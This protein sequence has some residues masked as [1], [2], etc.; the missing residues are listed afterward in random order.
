MLDNVGLIHMNGRVQDPVLGRFVSADPFITEPGNTQNFNRYSYVYNNPLAFTDPSGFD[1]CGSNGGADGSACAEEEKKKAEEAALRAR[2]S[3]AIARAIAADGL[4]IAERRAL[5]AQAN[6][7][8]PIIRMLE[9]RLLQNGSSNPSPNYSGGEVDAEI[10]VA[11]TRHTLE[12]RQL[13]NSEAAGMLAASVMPGL[14]MMWESQLV[15]Q[16]QAAA[17]PV[18]LRAMPAPAAGA[19]RTAPL[20]NMGKQGKH[21]VGHNN[22]IPGRSVLTGNPQVLAQR[23][24]TGSPVGSVA[25]GQAG[26][27]ERVDFGEIIGNYVKD[28]VST[29]TRNGIIT[30]AGDGS[31]HIIPAAP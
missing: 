4:S 10:V 3:E 9:Q 5:M 22:Y 19:A 11:G 28:G 2:I 27:K 13:T 23:A 17:A 6:N 8:I 14:A 20:V 31:I 16:Y 29:P 24:G 25:R 21:I 12:G 15:A 30:Y 18:T 7:Q 26:F 1:A